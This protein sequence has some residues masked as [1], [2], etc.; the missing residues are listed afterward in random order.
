M[1]MDVFLGRNHAGLQKSG[2]CGIR[3]L[4]LGSFLL[5]KLA[6]VPGSHLCSPFCTLLSLPFL[7]KNLIAFH[8]LTVYACVCLCRCVYYNVSVEAGKQLLTA[9]S[10]LRSGCWG[11]NLGHQ[12]PLPAEP[13]DQSAVFRPS[14]L[15]VVIVKLPFQVR[16]KQEG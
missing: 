14:G 8:L 6:Q 7:L 5:N 2:S 3:V 15:S 12:A 4:P 9:G 13:S 1:L 16:H 11:S 10:P